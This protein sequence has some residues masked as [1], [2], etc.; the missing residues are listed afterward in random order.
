MQAEISGFSGVGG[1]HP[2]V[3]VVAA[4]PVVN[5]STT[6][7]IVT[8]MQTTGAALDALTRISSAIPISTDTGVSTKGFM[9]LSGYEGSY[10]EEKA[11]EDVLGVESISTMKLLRLAAAQGISI[12]TIN[13]QNISSVLPTITTGLDVTSTQAIQTNIQNLVNQGLE[14][15]IPISGTT[16]EA[17]TGTGYIALNLTTGEGG[18]YLSGNL[19]GGMTVLALAYW[20]PDIGLPIIYPYEPVGPPDKNPDAVS[21]LVLTSPN[22]AVGTV[23]QFLDAPLIVQALDSSGVPVSGATITFNVGDGG[24]CIAPYDMTVLPLPPQLPVPVCTD[25]TVSVMTGYTGEAGVWFQL[26]KY[27]NVHPTYYMQPGDQEPT[28]AGINTL[29]AVSQN[30]IGLIGGYTAIARPDIPKTMTQIQDA[31]WG[32]FTTYMGFVAVAVQDRYNNPV[33]NVPV[34]FAVQPYQ[35]LGG[36]LGGVSDQ[37][38]NM[39]VVSESSFG[40]NGCPWM[41]TLN[42]TNACH[43]GSDLT[44]VTDFKGAMMG[45]ISGNLSNTIYT[46][47][48][49]NQELSGI[50]ITFVSSTPPDQDKVCLGEVDAYVPSTVDIDGHVLNAGPLGSKASFTVIPYEIHE[51]G[52]TW[53]GNACSLDCPGVYSNAAMVDTAT[54]TATRVAGTGMVGTAQH[55]GPATWTVPITLSATTPELEQYN[56]STTLDVPFTAPVSGTQ[57]TQCSTPTIAYLPT[58]NP[59]YPYYA[60]SISPVTVTPNPLILNN[61]SA[62]TTDLNITYTIQPPEYTANIAQVDLLSTPTSTTS[63]LPVMSF[64]GNTSG[65]GTETLNNGFQLDATKNY[66]VQ[67]VL[68]RGSQQEIDSAVVPFDVGS[69]DF[70][71]VS[72]SQCAFDPHETIVYA[73]GQHTTYIGVHVTSLGIPLSNLYVNFTVDNGSINPAMVVPDPNSG[74]GETTYISDT[75]TSVTNVNATLLDLNSPDSIKDIT[76]IIYNYNGYNFNQILTNNQFMTSPKSVTVSGSSATYDLSTQKGIEDWLCV[77]H[78]TNTDQDTN[79]SII[80]GLCYMGYGKIGIAD[81]TIPVD[82]IDSSLPQS[83][84]IK[85]DKE[86]INYN[87][88]T[89]TYPSSLNNCTR[90]VNGTPS[91]STVSTHNT[92]NSN[93]PVYFKTSLTGVLP[94]NATTIPVA[95]TGGAHLNPVPQSGN[96]NTYQL[97]IENEFVQ[98]TGKTNTSFTGCRSNVTTH[99]NGAPIYYEIGRAGSL[100]SSIIHNASIANN[101][102]SAVILT[103]LQKEQSL[104][105]TN[106]QNPLSGKSY[107][108][109]LDYGMGAVY[110]PS[111]IEDQ[112]ELGTEGYLSRWYTN[113]GVSFPYIFPTNIGYCLNSDGCTKDYVYVRMKVTN[114]ATYSLFKYTPYVTTSLSGGGNK[115]F[116]DAWTHFGFNQYQ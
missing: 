40:T 28:Q 35:Y 22:W 88:I 104:I 19:H 3:T 102:S 79:E 48:I 77:P 57:P 2:E 61:L 31:V 93:T 60:V 112:I 109:Q 116:Y 107:S 100:I 84:T 26:G 111:D 27:T 37:A 43:A 62:T 10:L 17:F 42:D 68:N 53:S 81:T 20:P 67:V 56:I 105:S 46:L 25:G 70:Q 106:P 23:G 99:N 16:Y 49:S 73:D 98:C 12:V 103:E 54:V 39:E 91:S 78:T 72:C 69:A 71:I 87:G 44:S 75:K 21:Q 66:A 14:V 45:L 6:L 34:Q 101:V 97:Y 80:S 115:V 96:P 8:S 113:P 13:Q 50:T 82:P 114:E 9:Y 59:P 7:G 51:I 76:K 55:V 110:E 94:A 30:N 95:T 33:S 63:W 89:A 18:Y 38:R 15:Q 5:V 47:D 108:N 32:L 74:K 85:I 52:C 65:S 83:G 24:G 29:N 41:P 1:V 64:V 92:G 90:G 36:S 4:K 11:F 86:E 58:F